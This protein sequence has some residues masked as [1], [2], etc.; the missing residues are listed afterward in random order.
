MFNNSTMDSGKKYSNDSFE[1]IIG[2]MVHVDGTLKSQ[3]NVHIQGGFKGTL[4]IAHKL[5]LGKDAHVE[6]E[7]KVGSAFVAGKITG[8]VKVEDILEL[9]ETALIDGDVEAGT[10]IM[11]AGARMNGRCTMGAKKHS[12]T[13][14]NNGN[15]DSKKS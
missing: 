5:K 4:E 2:P 7:V 12:A 6:A 3:G 13:P 15:P 14:T 10:I 9:S 8:N 1:T 11:A